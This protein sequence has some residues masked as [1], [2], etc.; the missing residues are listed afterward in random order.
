[1]GRFHPPGS[2]L[3]EPSPRAEA[4]GERITRAPRGLIAVL[5]CLLVGL[6][7]QP[8][9][10]SRADRAALAGEPGSGPKAWR[11]HGASAPDGVKGSDGPKEHWARAAIDHV[12]GTNDWM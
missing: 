12:G 4:P 5:T 3:K 6:L 8:A 1:M 2:P 11:G 10:S 9:S 7:P